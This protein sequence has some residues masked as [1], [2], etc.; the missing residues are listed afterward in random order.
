M[1]IQ[2]A[3]SL[4]QSLQGFDQLI[5]SQLLAW[6]EQ[7]QPVTREKLLGAFEDMDYEQL[8]RWLSELQ[9]KRNLFEVNPETT[10]P[11][12]NRPSIHGDKRPRN[13]NA[14]S[15]DRAGLRIMKDRVPRDDA[16]L[17]LHK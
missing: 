6:V 5:R 17:A 8:Q 7:N 1:L 3:L 16:C 10:T 15:E 12:Y 11:P 14:C 13:R 4:Y 9:R 2:S